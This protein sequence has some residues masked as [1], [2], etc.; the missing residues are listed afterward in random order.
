M[1]FSICPHSSSSMNLKSDLWSRLFQTFPLSLNKHPISFFQNVCSALA[2]LG[3]RRGPL[4]NLPLQALL[5]RVPHCL[6]E[7]FSVSGNLCIQNSNSVITETSYRSHCLLQQAEH[8]WGLGHGI[9]GKKSRGGGCWRSEGS[10][11][12]RSFLG[13]C[14]PA[15]P[16][17]EEIAGK[18]LSEKDLWPLTSVPP[19]WG[20]SHPINNESSK[21]VGIFVITGCVR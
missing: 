1:I 16:G 9:S 14:C 20:L 7:Y 13:T 17:R 10:E 6:K 15:L 21:K 8:S 2:S 5:S 12:Q 19:V 4:N 3:R 18:H 11:L